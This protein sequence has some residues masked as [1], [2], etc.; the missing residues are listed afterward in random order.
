M[1]ATKNHHLSQTSEYV[2]W[3]GMKRRCYNVNTPAYKNY[4][5]RGIKVCDRWKDSFMNFYTDMSPKPSPELTLERINN[6]GDYSPENC[7]WATRIEQ[8]ENRRDYSNNKLGVFGVYWDR[9]KNKFATSIRVNKKTIHL[10]RYN[11]LEEASD[12]VQEKIRQIKAKKK[13]EREAQKKTS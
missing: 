13:A 1:R 4:G 7:R 12:V 11:N 3:K 2:A 9:E 6:D 10:G 8:L 5:G